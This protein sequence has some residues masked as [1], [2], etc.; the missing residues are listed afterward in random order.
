VTNPVLDDLTH[1]EHQVAE[2][3]DRSTTTRISRRPLRA[4]PLSRHSLPVTAETMRARS[5]RSPSPHR[6]SN[7]RGYSQWEHG[8]ASNLTPGVKERRVSST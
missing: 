2:L 3:T 4:A 8:G 5:F 6:L 7:Q 1:L